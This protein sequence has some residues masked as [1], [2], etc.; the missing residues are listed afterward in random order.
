M[1][2]ALDI[3]NISVALDTNVLLEIFSIHDL[4][5]KYDEIGGANVDASALVFRRAR[6][7]E[8][9]LLAMHLNAT[10][11]CTFSLDHEFK[12]LL[13]ARVP[14]ATGQFTSHFTTWFVNFV[15]ERLLPSWKIR[16][17]IRL[18]SWA[19]RRRLRR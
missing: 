14:P 13:L 19:A 11:A 1:H 7:R 2:N 12:K 5:N 8:S 17:L 16:H 6:A 3:S 10:N 18:R 4:V 15:T 9:L